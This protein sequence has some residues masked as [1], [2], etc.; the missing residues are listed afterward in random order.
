MTQVAEPEATRWV[1]GGLKRKED[2]KLITGQG[3]YTEDIALPGMLW[4]AFVRS[5]VAHATIAGIDTSAAKE[6]PGVQA[7]FTGQELADDWAAALPCA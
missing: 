2:P 6:L 7:V 4:L 5:P 3:R 1:G